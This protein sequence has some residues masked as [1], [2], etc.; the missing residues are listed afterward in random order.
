MNDSRRN[1]GAGSSELIVTAL[2]SHFKAKRDAAVAQLSVFINNSAGVPDH[3]T[4]VSDCA[5]LVDEIAAAEE[6]LRTIKGLF[7]SPQSQV[8]SGE[9]LPPSPQ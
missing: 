8:P 2:T 5:P 3:T 9:E 7:V 6:S 1:P 4:L